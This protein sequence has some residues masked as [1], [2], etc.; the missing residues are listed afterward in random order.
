MTFTLPEVSEPRVIV[1]EQQLQ[2]GVVIW[3]QREIHDALHADHE[4]V[5]LDLSEVSWL[6]RGPWGPR[7][8][9]PGVVA[10]VAEQRPHQDYRLDILA[11]R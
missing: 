1:L 4:R 10:R 7:A 2:A 6:G 9:L 3:L 8:T 5:V 11:R